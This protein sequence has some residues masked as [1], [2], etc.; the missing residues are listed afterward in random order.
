LDLFYLAFGFSRAFFAQ[1]GALQNRSDV[2]SYQVAAV[3]LA[4]RKK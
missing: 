4:T 2:A 1:V 3:M